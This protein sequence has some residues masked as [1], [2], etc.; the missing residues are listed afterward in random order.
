[1]FKAYWMLLS[2][3]LFTAMFAYAQTEKSKTA[4]PD[5]KLPRNGNIDVKHIA[6]D[7]RFD[8]YEKKAT[9]SATIR[10]AVLKA[11]DKITLDAAY[12][13]MLD[14]TD[15]SGHKF[16]FEYKGGEAYDNLGIDLGTVFNPEQEI[17]IVIKYETN[18][19]NE[20]DPLNLWGSYGKGIRYFHPTG[21]EPRKRKQVWSSGAPDNNRYWYPCYEN[22]ADLLT[23]EF[24]ATVDNELMTISNGQLMRK[25]ENKDGTNTWTWEMKQPHANHQTSFIIGYYAELV[26]QW[27]NIRLHN[28]AYPDEID[29]VK[30]STVRLSDMMSFFSVKTGT[31][32]PFQSYS[33]VFVQD[34]PWGGGHN[35]GLSTISENMI[36]DAGTHADFFYLW[37]G[38][39]A[40]DLAAQWY[41]NWIVP[42]DWADSWLSKSFARYFDGLY[43]EYKNGF[44]EFQFW[45]RSFNLNSYLADWNAGIRRPIVTNRYDQTSTMFND[46]YA[47][48]RGAE[49]LHM[50][51]SQI[52]DEAWWKLIRNYTQQYGGKLVET[53]DFKKVVESVA[54]KSMDWFF[55]Q[56][57]YKTGHPVFKVEKVYDPVKKQL[58]I[59]VIQEQIPD[60]ISG[61]PAAKY[62]SGKVG[63]ELDDSIK[64]IWLEAK[65]V[66]TFSF[67][68]STTPRLINFDYE[69]RW[70][71]EVKEE[72]ST[73]EWLW[74]LDH[75]RDILARNQALTVLGSKFTGSISKQD[76]SRII[77]S[78]RGIVQ[79][80]AYW[81]LKATALSRIRSVLK[82]PYDKETISMLLSI[83]ER[84][85]SWMRT[86]AISFLGF[87]KDSQFIP[88]Y[89]KYLSDTSDRVIN[90]AAIALGKTKDKSVFP[91]LSELRFKSSWKNQSLISAL[92]G[93]KEL[94]DKRAIPI[95]LEAL[96]DSPAMPRWTLATSTWDFRIAAA[97]TLV[98]LD[99]RSQAHD[100]VYKRYQQ[101]LTDN[102]ISDI[103]N[104]VLLIATIGDKRSKAIFD[105]L[106]IKFKDHAAALTAIAQYE[107][108]FNQQL[109]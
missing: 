57:L 33:Q 108:Q 21:T 31:P 28:Y 13:N 87:S 72:K 56:W 35:A 2:A 15:T 14:V 79:G 64:E 17:V 37:D 86:S 67:D 44:D 42:K 88:L 25:K 109:K 49:V 39:E 59:T 50:L 58:V 24:T 18:W 81:R 97:E 90:A 102:D 16:N 11:V 66:N 32:Y 76:S 61:Y 104:N 29:A 6:I 91:I 52:G 9:G 10:L 73:E 40:N 103:F 45:N 68:L 7:L 62:F 3:L 23:T 46:N 78:F 98:A 75:S 69:S 53:T 70:I 20:A 48:L 93:M 27:G 30:A 34:F 36:D 26:Q 106:K 85:S 19:Q 74:L 51:R 82:P 77:Q 12:M 95:A 1:M 65:P 63:I 96:K 38:V 101:S 94:G 84:D 55:D 54:G 80:D 105:Q 92:N 47:S 43:S 8:L 22:P 107:E 83:I 60:T 99:A 100:I 71:K 41:G 89:R 4:L 5:P